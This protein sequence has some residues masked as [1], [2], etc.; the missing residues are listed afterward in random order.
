MMSAPGE[1]E[2]LRPE[3]LDQTYTIDEYDVGEQEQSDRIET[4]HA[5][6]GQH[7]DIIAK[8]LLSAGLTWAGVFA[9]E[10]R[11]ALDILCSRPDVD[12]DQVGCCGLSLGGLRTNYLAGLD[13]RIRCSVTVGFMTTW[14]DLILHNCY[15]H[16]WMVYI[17]LLAR[18]MDFPEILG[19]R[20]P[21]PAMVLSTAEDPLFSLEEV[22]LAL[23]ILRQVYEKAGKPQNFASGVFPGPHQFNRA[24][25][26]QAFEWLDRHLK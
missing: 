14:R 21:L 22:R 10:D 6:A 15:T 12:S 7:E 24:M 9:A 20:A 26:A 4:Y 23:S 11:M 13:D 19:L 8:S 2:E 3:D 17:P 16:S 25:Q 18:Y 1:A 5:F